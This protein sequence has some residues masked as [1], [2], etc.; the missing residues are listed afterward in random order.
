[1]RNTRSDAILFGGTHFFLHSNVGQ[2]YHCRQ[3]G[4]KGIWGDADLFVVSAKWVKQAS[5]KVARKA[6]IQCLD[7]TGF[8]PAR[9]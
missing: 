4:A 3:I 5:R 1:M 7:L 9:E 6:E 2:L 8:P